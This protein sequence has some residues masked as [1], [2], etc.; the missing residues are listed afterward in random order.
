MS[1]QFA[2]SSVDPVTDEEVWESAVDAAERLIRRESPTADA[3]ANRKTSRREW[4]P[5]IDVSRITFSLE[6]VEV[7]TY[8]VGA[9]TG[10][11]AGFSPLRMRSM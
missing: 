3:A 9:C 5:D 10:R 1:R 8:F 11:S 4:P 6:R 7:P 2:G